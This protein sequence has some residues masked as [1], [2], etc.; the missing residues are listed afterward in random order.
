MEREFFSERIARGVLPA[1]LTAT[2]TENPFCTSAYVAAMQN[3]GNDCWMVGTRQGE[4][5][6]G[7]AIALY[8]RGRISRTLEIPSLPEAAE[9]PAFWAGIYSLCRRLRVTDLIAGTFSS[10]QFCLPPLRGEVSRRERREYIISLNDEN[11]DSSLSSNHKRNIKKASGAELTIRAAK[12]QSDLLAEHVRLMEQSLERRAARGESVLKSS[13]IS[14]ESR[15]YL[16]SGA[17]ELYQATRH[18][19]VVSS[20]L[21]LR[22]RHGAYYHSAGT[23]PEGMSVGASHFLVYSVCKELRK[24]GVCVFNLGGAPQDSSLARFKA[25]FGAR[26]ISLAAACCYL[27]PR[28]LKKTR[29]AITL[30]GSDRTR[31]W[32]FLRGSRYRLLVFAGETDRCRE[33]PGVAP[34]IR[35]E[36][37]SEDQIKAIPVT[38]ENR[39]FRERQLERLRQL[40]GSRP[41]GVYVGKSLAHVSWLLPASVVAAENPQILQLKDEEAEI[42]GCETL[43][44]FRGKNLYS[45]A[46]R[47]ISQI[48]GDLG[49]RRIY[50]KTI[51][52]NSASQSG[53]LKAG[54]SPIGSITVVT[55]PLTSRR[56]LVLRRLNAQARGS[57]RKLR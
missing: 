2:E 47:N 57:D 13:T 43:P 7:I 25:G 26:E 48:A 36:M 34:E 32:Q 23:S 37:L 22:S 18:G 17:G 10:P 29:T 14:E 21:L 33:V 45:F 31:L 38:V 20:I 28:W 15:A 44:E 1:E 27:G 8:R 12:G 42:T 16:D 51:D 30:L 46:I 11:W 52:G 56:K 49:I 9:D 41:Y 4:I 55:P 35:F 53:I 5:V 50:M 40:P 6:Q 24:I 3:L 39:E 19:V 54:L